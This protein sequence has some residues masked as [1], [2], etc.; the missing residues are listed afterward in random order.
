MTATKP[1]DPKPRVDGVES[2]VSVWVKL[3]FQTLTHN[4]VPIYFPLILFQEQLAVKRV[5][6]FCEFAQTAGLF[7]SCYIII[8]EVSFSLAQPICKATL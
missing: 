3:T 7:N 5:A 2:S 6:A 1:L 8:A 4:L